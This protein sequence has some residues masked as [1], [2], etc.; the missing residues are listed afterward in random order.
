[1][2]AL[3]TGPII[4]AA[5]ALPTP[6]ATSLLQQHVNSTFEGVPGFTPVQVQPLHVVEQGSNNIMQQQLIQGQV[7]LNSTVK[8]CNEYFSTQIMYL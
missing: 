4:S 8:F 6:F 7:S 3:F 2:H 5:I 1:M